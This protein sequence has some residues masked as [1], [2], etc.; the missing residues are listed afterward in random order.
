MNAFIAALT[1]AL[2]IGICKALAKPGVMLGLVNAWRSA[3]EPQQI[4][5][6][7]PNGEDVAFIKSAEADGWP[8]GSVLPHSNTGLQ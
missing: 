7:K 1:E 5:A 6:S 4:I 3:S 8:S 2:V